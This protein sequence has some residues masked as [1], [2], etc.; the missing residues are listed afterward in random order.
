MQLPPMYSALK[1]DGVRLYTLAREG[2]EIEREKRPINVY[3]IKLLN[4]KN[5][6]GQILMKVSKGTYV[7]S[8]IADLGESLSTGAI[9]TG[10]VR[11]ETGSYNIKDS[12]KIDEFE[13][14]PEKYIIAMDKVL[15]EYEK[16]IIA[17]NFLKFLINGV[18]I[19]DKALIGNISPGKYRTYNS[20]GDFLGLS[21]RDEISLFLKINLMWGFKW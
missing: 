7:R 18:K 19:R 20:K 16:L 12:I 3:D 17:E 21:V 4:Y 10:L 9:M 14:N 6:E 2:I 1:K 13:K 5:G 11:E 8:I 15:D